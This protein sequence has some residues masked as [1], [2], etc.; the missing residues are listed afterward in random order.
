[1]KQVYIL[2]VGA[3]PVGEHY[4]RTLVDLAL[5]S[6]RAALANTQP[7]IAPEQLGALYVANAFG[8]VLASHSHLG[9]VLA[10]A[11]GLAGIEALRVEAAGASGGVALRQAAQAIA[12]GEHD[13][14]A[15]VGVEKVTDRF[16]THLASA[17][18]L[19]LDS[20][21]EYEHGITLSAQW[22]MLMR[23]YMH[24]YSYDADAFAPFPINAHNNGAANPGALYRFKI[25]SDKYRKAG[26][27]ASPLNMLDCSSGGDGAA[28]VLLASER[29]AHECGLPLVRLAG[30]SLATDQLALFERPEPLWLAAVQ[31][32]ARAALERAGVSHA[33]IDVLELTDPHSITAAMALESCGFIEPGT[34]PRHAADGGIDPTGAT[35]LATAGGYK[36]RGDVGGASGVYQVVELVRQLRG[37]A[38]A[39][40][41]PEARTAFAQCLGGVASTAVTHILKREG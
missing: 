19:A 28:T 12:S 21:F 1:M 34:A 24:R 17:Q 38:G 8:E 39:A 10:S 30:S 41:V 33:D 23:R 15:V 26:Q 29:L 18:A 3:S 22:A 7:A 40:Q 5:T 20:D 37:E 35:P 31:R 6:L 9:A 32:S 14:V 4:T 25:N 27:L 2:G 36:A 13:L 16:D 11:A